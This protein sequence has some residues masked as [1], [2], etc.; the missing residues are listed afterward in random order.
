MEE[1]GSSSPSRGHCGSWWYTVLVSVWDLWA[2]GLGLR[3]ASEIWE[4]D[5][6]GQV[7]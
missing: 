4:F 2:G 7:I 1:A 3:L 5:D 6:T